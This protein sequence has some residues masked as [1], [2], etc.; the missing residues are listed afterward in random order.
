MP[1][2]ENDQ[3]L[4]LLISISTQLYTSSLL[5]LTSNYQI[6]R[7]ALTITTANTDIEQKWNATPSFQMSDTASYPT[8]STH[9]SIMMDAGRN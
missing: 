9:G 8:I 7:L 3:S 4:P 5:S 6:P 1:H 2:E